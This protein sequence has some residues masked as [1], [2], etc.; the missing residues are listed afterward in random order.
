MRNTNSFV[1]TLLFFAVS[2]QAHAW[3][4]WYFIFKFTEVNALIRV[5]IALLGFFWL[6]TFISKVICGEDENPGC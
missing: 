3:G 2:I 5:I 6:L 4:L 1:I